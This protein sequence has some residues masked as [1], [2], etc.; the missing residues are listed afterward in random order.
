MRDIWAEISSYDNM[1]GWIVFLIELP[2]DI[3]RHILEKRQSTLATRIS[4]TN[5]YK[6]RI[7]EELSSMNRCIATLLWATSTTSTWQEPSAR[8]CSAETVKQGSPHWQTSQPNQSTHSAITPRL[9]YLSQLHEITIP[10][11]LDVVLRECLGRAINGVLLHAFTHVRIL[12]YSL[13]LFCRHFRY[14]R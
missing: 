10:H 13:S 14:L 12:D 3:G 11:L 7:A 2:L 9:H 4:T 8:M 1:P 5:L 6:K